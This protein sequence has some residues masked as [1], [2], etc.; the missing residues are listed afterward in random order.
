MLAQSGRT[1]SVSFADTSPA[2][3]NLLENSDDKVVEFSA[4]S[5]GGGFGA[6]DET[7]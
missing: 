7:A 4:G 3:L 6:S 1:P 5:A 2:M